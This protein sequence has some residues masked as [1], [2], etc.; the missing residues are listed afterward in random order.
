MIYANR[1]LEGITRIVVN[2]GMPIK[3][4]EVFR[5]L[6]DENFRNP[7]EA[8]RSLPISQQQ[9]SKYLNHGKKDVP[10]LDTSAALA[11]YFRISIDELAGRKPIPRSLPSSVVV[12]SASLK[13]ISDLP[14]RR[15]ELIEVPVV[16]GSIAAGTG[17]I[18][19][20]IVEDWAWIPV[21][22]LRGRSRDDLVCIRVTGESMEPIIRNGAMI[23]VDRAARP[24]GK[25]DRDNAIYAVRTAQESISVKHVRISDHLMILISSNL[26][27]APM[28]VDMRGQASP[29]IGQVVWVWQAI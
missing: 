3:F 6:I 18:P 11:D 9:I 21:E 7:T 28:T 4:K 13:N 23:C 15:T 24:A 16:S 20:D 10:K 19:D 26:S 25:K 22:Q 8:A 5:D 14:E 29:I 2:I 27:Q 17:R 12:R 1:E